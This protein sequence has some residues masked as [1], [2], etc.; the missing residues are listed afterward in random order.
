MRLLIII[1]F[2]LS[3]QCFS[4][5]SQH[6]STDQ[7]LLTN[8]LTTVIRDRNNYMWVGSYNGLH[9]HEGSRIKTFKRIGKDSASISGGEMHGLFEDK[10]G[11]IWI[12]TTAG[13]DRID[14]VT[15]NIKHYSVR[16]PN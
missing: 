3:Q 16:N 9:K 10:D 1:L 11:F 13:L 12:G 7:G 15:N 5:S 4:Q 2:F 14:P 8:M 6:I